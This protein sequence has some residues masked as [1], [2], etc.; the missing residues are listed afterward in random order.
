[1]SLST[2][3]L[4][5]GAVL[6]LPGGL[7]AAALMSQPR[8]RWL[9]LVGG[10]LGAAL[11]A[12]ALEYFTHAAGVTIDAVSWFLGVFLACSMGVAIGAL[13]VGFFTGASRS[14]DTNALE[15]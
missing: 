15:S 7:F 1:M 5:I 12:I 6:S 11:T 9:G 2:T 4:I 13:L 14:S 3:L 8:A 10:V